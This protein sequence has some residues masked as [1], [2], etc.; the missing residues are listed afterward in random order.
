[1]SAPE[2]RGDY[3]GYRRVWTVME[4]LAHGQLVASPPMTQRFNGLSGYFPGTPGEIFYARPDAV[5]VEHMNNEEHKQYD[6]PH[7]QR[8]AFIVPLLLPPLL[9]PSPFVRALRLANGAERAWVSIHR[10]LRVIRAR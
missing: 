3:A 10:D 7:S 9:Q 2:T 6:K 4:T 1:M 5:F 8:R